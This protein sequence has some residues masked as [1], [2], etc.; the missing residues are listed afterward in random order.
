MLSA[1]D[2]MGNKDFLSH[3]VLGV[4]TIHFFLHLNFAHKLSG[5]VLSHGVTDEARY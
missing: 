2:F 5:S 1:E 3:L 4:A